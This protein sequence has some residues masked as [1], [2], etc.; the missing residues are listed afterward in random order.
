MDY[1]IITTAPGSTRETIRHR[2]ELSGVE[3]GS[4]STWDHA[5]ATT[6]AH[7]R[8]CNLPEGT[9][10]SIDRRRGAAM[11]RAHRRYVVEGGVTR[12]TDR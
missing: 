5:S 12:R 8:G 6:W 3:H 2:E 10:I 1:R 7:T 9:R 11:Y 4:P